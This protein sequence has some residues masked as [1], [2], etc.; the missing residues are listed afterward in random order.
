MAFWC[1]ISFPPQRYVSPA[2]VCGETARKV[3]QEMTQSSCGRLVASLL[4]LFALLKKLKSLHTNFVFCDVRESQGYM[5]G[6]HAANW[7]CVRLVTRPQLFKRF[8]T[9]SS[10]KITI[11]SINI[12]RV[13][14]WPRFSYSSFNYTYLERAY[15]RL[16]VLILT[17]LQRL[18]LTDNGLSTG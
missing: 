14:S 17:S 15:S 2:N 11:Q 18:K 6:F 4:E 9:L 3:E 10:G 13:K 7:G 1:F 8:I 12:F 5:N 16:L